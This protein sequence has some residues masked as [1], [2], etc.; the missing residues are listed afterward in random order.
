MVITLLLVINR[1]F[2][3]AIAIN[4]NVYHLSPHNSLYS[5]LVW[6]PLGSYLTYTVNLIR[7]G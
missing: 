5:L 4:E 2:I 3:T 7:S 1:A 6:C